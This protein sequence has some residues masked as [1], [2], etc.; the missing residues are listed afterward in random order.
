MTNVNVE[1]LIQ[2]SPG[3]TCECAPSGL[4]GE[5]ESMDLCGCGEESSKGC[6]GIKDDRVYSEYYCDSCFEKRK[7]VKGA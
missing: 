1:P 3:I 2:V 5:L 7:Q 4:S 6:H